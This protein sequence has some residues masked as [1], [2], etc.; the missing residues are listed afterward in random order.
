[1]F[2]KGGISGFLQLEFVVRWSISCPLGSV[3]GTFFFQRIPKKIRLYLQQA[4]LRRPTPAR[5]GWRLLF[6]LESGYTNIILA[7]YWPYFSLVLPPLPLPLH[8]LNFMSMSIFLYYI[9]IILVNKRPLRLQPRSPSGG[10]G[11]AVG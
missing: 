6:P 10:S 8:I 1:M 4:Y 11:I 9:N 7:N 2:P 3:F 5:R